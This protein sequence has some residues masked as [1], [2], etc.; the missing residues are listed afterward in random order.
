MVGRKVRESELSGWSIQARSPKPAEIRFLGVDF[1]FSGFWASARGID[2]L[3]D[4]AK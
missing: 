4:V 2:S 3:V 1:G